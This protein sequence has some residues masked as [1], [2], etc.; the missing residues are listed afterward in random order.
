LVDRLGSGFIT[1]AMGSALSCPLD[2]IRTRMQADSGTV[3][4]GKYVTGL[5]AGESV[6][7]RNMLV[8]LYKI[9][10]D[11]GFTRGLYRGASVTVARASVLGGS[12]LASYD[13]LKRAIGWDE[14]AALHVVCSLSSG[15]IAQTII[16]PMDTVK[17][18]M[19]LGTGWTGVIAA[20][21][22][23]GPSFLFRGYLPACC[24]Q[25][26]IMVIQMPVC[27]ELRRLMG[28]GAI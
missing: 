24:G 20:L 16:M 2:C 4:G 21:R 25:S 23:H 8:A 27:E 6:R 5:R 1:G 11:E 26:A 7:Y 10:R 18:H 17:S 3:L 22:G 14:G 9:A 13:T 15:I 19:M 28:E 12:Q